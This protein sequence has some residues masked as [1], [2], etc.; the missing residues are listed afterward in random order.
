VNY[1][2]IPTGYETHQDWLKA[3]QLVEKFG[4]DPE[5]GTPKF[6]DVYAAANGLNGHKQMEM[7]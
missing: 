2:T 5:T 1:S 4:V 6:P 7:A 3:N